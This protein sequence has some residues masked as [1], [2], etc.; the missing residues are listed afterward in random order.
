MMTVE[1]WEIS[2]DE[3]YSISVI[4]DTFAEDQKRRMLDEGEHKLLHTIVG[5]DWND[6]MTKYHEL[7][8]WEPYV[9]FD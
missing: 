5:K 2:Y 7:M 6:C 8:G 3:G 9:P 1:I 4:P